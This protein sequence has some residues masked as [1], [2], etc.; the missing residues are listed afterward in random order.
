MKVVAKFLS[1]DGSELTA[2]FDQDGRTVTDQNGRRGTFSRA[3]GSNS[4]E[5]DGGEGKLTIT[6]KDAVQFTPG[7]TTSFTASNGKSGTV[8]IVSVG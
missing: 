7:F 8:T 4:I 2:T 3:D 1:S 6:V 5:I